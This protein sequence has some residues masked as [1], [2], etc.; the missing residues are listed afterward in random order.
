MNETGDRHAQWWFLVAFMLITILEAPQTTTVVT[1]GHAQVCVQTI[2]AAA[3]IRK[4]ITAA[5]I[6]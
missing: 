4:G 3:I 5:L 1:A 2:D 6:E